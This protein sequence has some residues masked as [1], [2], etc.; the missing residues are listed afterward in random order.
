MAHDMIVSETHSIAN[1]HST[2]RRDLTKYYRR[3]KQQ[4]YREYEGKNII[5]V[6]K[7]W[8]STEY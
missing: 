3:C 6:P 2:D 8:V 1:K 4:L 7:Q 5:S